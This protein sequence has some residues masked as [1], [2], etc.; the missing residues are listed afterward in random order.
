MAG[1]I[2]LYSV[3]HSAENKIKEINVK[4]HP[5]YYYD[6]SPQDLEPGFIINV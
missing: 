4:S 3:E 6:Y 5:K 2:R 1:L